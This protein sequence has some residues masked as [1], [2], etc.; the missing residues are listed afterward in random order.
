MVVMRTAVSC[1]TILAVAFAVP[2][3]TNA[4]G[5]EMRN[6]TP[7]LVPTYIG[8]G[9]RPENK[10]SEQVW[11][12]AQEAEQFQLVG[13]QGPATQK[14]QVRVCYDRAALYVRFECFEDRVGSVL[15]KWARDDEPVWQDDSVELWLSP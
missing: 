11:S 2:L 8:A 13:F 4:D 7:V 3:S 5:G 12:A 14:T 10:I 6:D 1:A 9:Q 15:T